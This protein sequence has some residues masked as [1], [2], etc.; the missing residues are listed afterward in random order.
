MK[1]NVWIIDLKKNLKLYFFFE[2]VIPPKEILVLVLAYFFFKQIHYGEQIFMNEI[3]QDPITQLEKELME[4]EWKDEARQ[5][6]LDQINRD[7][8]IILTR[9]IND[10]QLTQTEI[11]YLAEVLQRYRPALRKHDP[12]GTI[13]TVQDNIRVVQSEK[14]FLEMMDNYQREQT[15]TFY[16]PLGDIEVRLDLMVSPITDSQA[17]LDIGNNLSMFKDLTEQELNIYNKTQQNEPLTRE[18]QIIADAVQRKV[19]QAT[20]EN[21]GEI[22]SEFLAMQTKLNEDSTYESMK[23]LYN[24]MQI[25]YRALLFQRVQQMSGL[26]DIDV[27]RAFR[28]AN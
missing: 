21:Q 1:P 5:I 4:T 23:E 8:R 27:D 17:I 6:P 10:E 28:D 24:R 9:F 26:G 13:E 2:K 3:E 20:K 15:I 12:T 22:M 18:E 25:G 11:D 14:Q 7:E 19:E 16:Y